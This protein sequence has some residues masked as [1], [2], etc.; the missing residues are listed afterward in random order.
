MKLVWEG[1]LGEVLSLPSGRYRLY[2]EGLSKNRENHIIALTDDISTVKSRGHG[3]PQGSLI[4]DFD[5]RY[6]NYFTKLVM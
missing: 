2:C 4:I 1:L 5:E 6:L 3:D